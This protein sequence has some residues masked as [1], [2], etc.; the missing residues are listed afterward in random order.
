MRETSCISAVNGRWLFFRHWARSRIA[1]IGVLDHPI[2]GIWHSGS[3]RVQFHLRWF[4]FS[5]L[6]GPETYRTQSRTTAQSRNCMI[7]SGR[8]RTPHGLVPRLQTTQPPATSHECLEPIVR[9]PSNAPRSLARM[10]SK[11]TRILP[12]ISGRFVRAHSRGPIPPTYGNLEC[13]TACRTTSDFPARAVA[14]ISRLI[15]FPK[16]D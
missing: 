4:D 12:S 11:Q 14:P 13:R 15:A 3:S 1:T 8:L 5:A 2:E 16:N 7:P 9:S 6:L 10:G